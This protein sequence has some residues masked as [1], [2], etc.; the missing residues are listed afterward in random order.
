MEK[1][2]Y[3]LLCVIFTSLL[4]FSKHYVVRKI[5]WFSHKLIIAILL[6]RKDEIKSS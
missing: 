4:T 2:I 5:V 1:L 6:D 3:Y